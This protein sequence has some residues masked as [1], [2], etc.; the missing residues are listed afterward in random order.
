MERPVKRLW[1]IDGYPNYFFGEDNELY[2]ITSRGELKRNPR[3][4]KRYTIGYTLKS[5]FYSLAQL[6]PLLRRHT[7]SIDHPAGF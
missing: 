5:R 3:C 6:R 1:D 4:M 2:R 7:P